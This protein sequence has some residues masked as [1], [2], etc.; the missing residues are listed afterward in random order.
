MLIFHCQALL[1]FQ[2]AQHN[3]LASDAFSALRA[4]QRF[5][6]GAV[7]QSLLYRFACFQDKRGSARLTYR[8][9]T[10]PKTLRL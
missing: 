8:P 3:R 4:R 1:P 5:P 9:G 10:S 2:Q 6:T 7:F